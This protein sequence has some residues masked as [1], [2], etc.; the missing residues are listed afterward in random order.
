MPYA[1]NRRDP[2]LVMVGLDPAAGF[3]STP[4]IGY[5]ARLNL[6]ELHPT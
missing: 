1:G 6:I 3:T 2:A 4:E 5:A